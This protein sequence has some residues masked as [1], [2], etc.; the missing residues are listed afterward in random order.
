MGEAGLHPSLGVPRDR[1]AEEAERLRGA[2]VSVPSS[3]ASARACVRVFVGGSGGWR[4]CVHRLARRFDPRH[5]RYTPDWVAV[6]VGGLTITAS[7]MVRR[8]AMPTRNPP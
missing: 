4:S 1:L 3:V 8:A 7:G 5:R 6:Q 2:R